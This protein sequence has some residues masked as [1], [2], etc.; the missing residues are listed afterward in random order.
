MASEILGESLDILFKCAGI[1]RQT[2]P[3][4]LEKYWK[5]QVISSGDIAVE[6]IPQSDLLRILQKSVEGLLTL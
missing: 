3:T 2:T 4:H 6:R 1:S 5:A